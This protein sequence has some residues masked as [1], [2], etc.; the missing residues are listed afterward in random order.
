M[1]PKPLASTASWKRTEK[2]AQF[3]PVESSLGMDEESESVS[4]VVAVV[5]KTNVRMY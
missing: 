1:A 5:D 2:M 4:K 3:R